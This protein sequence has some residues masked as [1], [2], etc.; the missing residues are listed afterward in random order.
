MGDNLLMKTIL[1]SLFAASTLIYANDQQ[2]DLSWVDKQV[3]AIKPPRDGESNR[4]ISRIK[5]PFIF[6]KK[7]SL[8]KDEDKDISSKS[9]RSPLIVNTEVK[10]ATSSSGSI[11]P[12]PV[13]YSKGSFV[14]SAI[15]NNSAMINGKWYKLGDVV[16]DYKIINVDNKTVTLKNNANTKVLTT[17]SKN[18]KLKF[19]K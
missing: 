6:L 17:A 1:I 14:L 13:V 18:S 15:I 11:K 5:N 9:S 7:N 16:N 10:S 4:N 8:K 12:K 2:I 19:K 3:E